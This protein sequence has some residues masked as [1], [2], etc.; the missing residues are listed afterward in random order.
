MLPVY[1]IGK[2]ADQL[3]SPMSSP[4]HGLGYGLA[5]AGFFE[6]VC[7]FELTWVVGLPVHGNAVECVLESLSR[8]GV[9]HAGLPKVSSVRSWIRLAYL[10]AS[11]VLVDVCDESNLGSCRCQYTLS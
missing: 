11:S 10:D 1:E 2:V 5:F 8:A 6:E 7:P 3:H 9:H 4:S